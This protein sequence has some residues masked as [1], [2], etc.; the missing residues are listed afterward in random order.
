M[1]RW[2]GTVCYSWRVSGGSGVTPDTCRLTPL[3]T[4]AK[5]IPPCYRLFRIWASVI[6]R[7][8]H[9]LSMRTMFSMNGQELGLS[10]ERKAGSRLIPLISFALR[11]KRF[12]SLWLE[13][14][15]SKGFVLP[16]TVYKI[17]APM[18]G[19]AQPR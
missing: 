13:Q 11:S 8:D 16:P 4:L 7:S 12:R 18:R 10:E 17:F 1:W 2:S 5:A 3:R 14:V 6:A 19:G 9:E 15:R